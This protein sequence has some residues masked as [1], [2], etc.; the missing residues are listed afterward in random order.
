M[1]CRP[2]SPVRAGGLPRYILTFTGLPHP[3]QGFEREERNGPPVLG[4]S[5]NGCP[6]CL[7][8]PRRE[9]KNC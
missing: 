8:T 4:G 1:G 2:G 7:H 3:G 9:L 6:Q 5:R